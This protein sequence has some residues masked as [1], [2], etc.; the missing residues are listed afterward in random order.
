MAEEQGTHE[1][2]VTLVEEAIDRLGIDHVKARGPVDERSTQCI[3]GTVQAWS[4]DERD[5]RRGRF[6]HV[7]AEQ[8]APRRA[9]L[10]G[11]YRELLP[12]QRVEQRGLAHVGSADNR[13]TAATRSLPSTAIRRRSEPAFRR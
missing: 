7:N 9:R 2:A 11:R 10:L 1:R 4:I 3:S 5:L 8:I 6:L 12:E 13:H